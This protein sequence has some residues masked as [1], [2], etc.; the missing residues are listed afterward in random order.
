MRTTLLA[1]ALTLS[2]GAQTPAQPPVTLE[3]K[4]AKDQLNTADD[5]AAAARLMADRNTAEGALAARELA[6]IAWFKG[7]P[8]PLVAQAED[9]FLKALGKA[10]RF[11]A[12]SG[13][14]TDPID[15]L[16]LDFLMPPLAPMENVEALQQKRLSPAWRTKDMKD[17]GLNALVNRSQAGRDGGLGPKTRAALVRGYQEDRIRTTDELFAAAKVFTQSQEPSDLL[18]ANELAALAAM[19]GD[20]PARILFAQ[21]WDR[22]ARALGQPAR[23]G[24]L[25]SQTMDPGVAPGVIRALGFSGRPTSRP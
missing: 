12:S 24:T 5:F 10:P 21:T 1:F 17:P 2:V 9:A 4:I 16:R 6:L 18:L 14:D 11:A 25:G 22:A 8:T 15:G 19:R 23:Y 20:L 13:G 7:K 3:E